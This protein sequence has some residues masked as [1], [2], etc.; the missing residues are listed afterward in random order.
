M[1][2]EAVPFNNRA[3]PPLDTKFVGEIDG[4]RRVIG[5]EIIDPLDPDP[6]VISTSLVVEAQDDGKPYPERTIA[7][8]R[9][10]QFKLLPHQITVVNLLKD[11]S[12]VSDENPHPTIK[13]ESIPLL[14]APFMGTTYTVLEHAKEMYRKKQAKKAAAEEESV[15]EFRKFLNGDR[16]D[17]ANKIQS[18][19]FPDSPQK[20]A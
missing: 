3:R 18:E 7:Y 1:G 6:N 17:K 14:R 12:N 5:T 10:L 9:H 15:V 2:K 11:Y 8:N 20:A 16:D 19:D 4:G 13:V